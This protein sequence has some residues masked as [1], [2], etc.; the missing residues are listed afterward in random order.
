MATQAIAGAVNKVLAAALPGLVKPIGMGVYNSSPVLKKIIKTNRRP[1]EGE[2]L[3]GAVVT[4]TYGKA[5]AYANDDTVSTTAVEP[6][7]AVQWELGGYQVSI[8]IPGQK[9]RKVQSSARKLFELAKSETTLAMLDM[10]EL[11]STHLFQATNEPKGIISLSTMSDASTTLAG[12]AASSTWGGSTTASG[13]FASQGKADLMTLYLQLSRYQG[14]TT[15]GGEDTPDL[16]VTRLTEWQL[17]WASLESSMRYAPNGPGD[18]KMQVTFMG[19]PVMKD[20]HVAA[21]VW[22]MLNTDHLWLYVMD[23]ADF[24]L[25]PETRDTAQPDMYARAVIWNGQLICDSRRYLG[26]LTG[27]S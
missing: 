19:N 18:V 15:T 20:E 3:Q 13:A 12:L 17:Y 23:G 2:S 9:I 14:F 11:M 24:E 27:L 6:F 5:S 25:M 16:C 8:N 4:S 26:K 22:Y 10:Y 21:G 7:T 1:W